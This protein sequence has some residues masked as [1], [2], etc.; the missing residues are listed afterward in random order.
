MSKVSI[1]F[2]LNF[3]KFI[4]DKYEFDKK[5]SAY[6]AGAV[7]DASM[8]LSPF[9]GFVIVSYLPLLVGCVLYI[10]MYDSVEE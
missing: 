9:L 10:Y 5:T 8:V 6:L 7:Y 1:S 4:Q 3:S 2:C